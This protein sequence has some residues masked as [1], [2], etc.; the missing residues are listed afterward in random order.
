MV[1]PSKAVDAG[2]CSKARRTTFLQFL[3]EAKRR[4]FEDKEPHPKAKACNIGGVLCRL[5]Y[6]MGHTMF[7]LPLPKFSRW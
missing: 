7:H 5:M 6:F 4:L 1:K 2:W 3:L